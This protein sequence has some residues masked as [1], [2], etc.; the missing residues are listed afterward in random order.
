MA[1]VLIAGGGIAGSALAIMLGRAGLT[2]ELFERDRFP[3][4]KACG[5]GLMPGGLAVLERL[6]LADTIGGVPFYG[7]RYFAGSL[8]AE[9][10]FPTVAGIPASGRGQ[11]RCHLDHTLFAAA[12]ATT[13]VTACESTPVEAPLWEGG[14]VAG[15]VVAGRPRRAPLVVAA[16][17]ARSRLRCQLGLDGRPPRRWRVGMRMHFRL[18]PSRTQPPWVEVF[19]GR[20]HELYV[21]PLPDGEILVA[22]LAERSCI[23]GKAET[24]Y[25]RWIA[26]Q[27]VLRMRLAGA[28]RSS[29]LR[30]MA[31]LGI[32]ARSGVAFGIVLL[33]DAAGA[34]D[35]ITGGGMAQALLTAE[36]LAGY[37]I[38]HW[39]TGNGWLWEYDR[40]RR[41]L[42]WDERVLTQFVLGL[43]AHPWLARQTLRLLNATP[44]L[45][46]HLVG[47]AGGIGGISA[48]GGAA[49]SSRP[50]D[51]KRRGRAEST[52]DMHGQ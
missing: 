42:L 26:E 44:A 31:P 27:P 14:R 52:S 33:G 15:L 41:A 18:A 24:A 39:A 46:S 35:P 4:E 36:L 51:I 6:G 45:F 50:S 22:S 9:G 37:V 25:E 19:L 47:I 11:R 2:V 8:V 30:G 28:E 32:R 48:C 5:E 43:A 49:L 20:H 16:D 34:L 1:D 40:A 10:R 13:G 3:R 23:E 38:R 7:V 21:T 12:A 17:G 29:R